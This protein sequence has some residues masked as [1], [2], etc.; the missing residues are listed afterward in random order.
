MTALMA[1]SRHSRVS[2]CTSALPNGVPAERLSRIPLEPATE[3]ESGDASTARLGCRRRLL[4]SF[5]VSVSLPAPEARSVVWRH[6]PVGA[7]TGYMEKLR[8]DWPAQV[9]EAWAV[10][11]FAVE[12]SALSEPELEALTN[13]LARR[14]SLPFRYLSIHGPSKGR[15][16]DEEQLVES[17]VRLASSAHAVVMHPDTVEDPAAYRPLGRKLLLENMDA[18]KEGGRTAEELAPFF[19]ELPDAGFC[20]DI[21]H[22]WSIDPDMSVA[23]ELL[24]GFGDR[25]GHVHLSSLSSELRHVPLTEEH[26]EL[27][28]P[29]LQR[30][31]DVPWILE[32]PP[33][34]P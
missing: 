9:A 24:D 7:S 18:R 23:T 3:R 26:E 1:A 25:L 5:G 13:Y 15:Q 34:R 21:A 22:A 2:A 30:C 6:H 31:L 32:A 12:L 4:A 33:R 14:P 20:F 19:D 17:L 28:K 10:S 29:L 27:F 16:L 8:G 11:S